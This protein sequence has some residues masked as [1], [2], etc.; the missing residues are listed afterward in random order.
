MFFKKSEL[1]YNRTVNYILSIPPA[2]SAGIEK[3]KIEAPSIFI[4]IT[5]T[6]KFWFNDSCQELKS[7]LLS[8]GETIQSQYL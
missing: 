4:Y 7:D 2:L 6:M 8:C 5:D 3:R 1:E